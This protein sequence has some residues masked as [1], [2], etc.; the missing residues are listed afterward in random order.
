LTINFTNILKDSLLKI[1]QKELSKI[2]KYKDAHKGEDCYFFGNGVSLKWFDFKE[3]SNKITIGASHLPLHRSFNDLNARYLLLT[4][5]FW[6]Y[7]ELITKYVTNSVSQPSLSK[8]YRNVIKNNP[9]TQFFLNLSNFLV[10]KSKNISFMF[11]DIIDP[12]LP[13]NF[14]TNKISSFDGSLRVAILLAI[15]MGFDHIYLVGCDYTHVPSRNLHWYEKG[16]GIFIPH[17]NYE[18]DFFKVA[19]EFIDITTITL[20]GTSDFID[21]VTYKEHTGVQ[22]IFRENTEL[23]DEKSMKILDTWHDYSIY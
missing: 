10:I 15:Y 16:R 14:I 19:K 13:A 7:P 17:E 3:F 2:H 5:P 21:S 6:F 12:R 23:L 11:R 4:E 1:S 8:E 18:K 20:D 9:D 22:P